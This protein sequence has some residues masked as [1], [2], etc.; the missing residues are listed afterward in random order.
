MSEQILKALM[1][2]FAIIANVDLNGN[3]GLSRSV[4][5]SYLEK[6]LNKKLQEEYIQVFDE[7][8]ALHHSGFEGYEESKKRTS[9]NSVQLLK[10]C[11]Q[12]NK[13]LQQEQKIFVLI[14]LLEF[15]KKGAEI[16]ETEQDFAST[17]A[18]AFNISEN[19]YSTLH[20]FV[21][22]ESPAHKIKNKCIEV[23]NILPSNQPDGIKHIFKDGLN[24]K[25]SFLHI[26]S[27]NMF[28]FKYRGKSN[29]YL[30]GNIVNADEPYIFDKGSAIRGGKL[31]PIY[32]S[33]IVAQFL[34]RSEKDKINF[35][36][37]N[38]V[39]KFKNSDAGIQKFN[40][41]ESSGEL[42]GIMGGSG[43]GKSTLLNIL[44]GNLKPQE[45][46]VSVNGIN[47]HEEKELLEGVIGFV[48]QDDLLIEELT[49]Y[50]NLYYN[51]RLCFANL[52]EEELLESVTKTLNDL[53]LSE[54]K[55]LQVGNPLNKVISG[56]QRKR[57]NIALELIREPSILFVDEPTSG[58]SS[59]DSEMVMDL[60]KE[61]THK[62]KLVIINIHQPS[63][64][65]YKMFD[66]LVMLDK[67]GYL[68]YYGNPLE[69][70][71]YFKKQSGFANAD[72]SEC[73]YCGNVNPEQ[74]L[75]IIEGKIV[76]ENGK[77][78]KTRKK[79]P[80]EW[81]KLYNTELEKKV[82]FN[83]GTLKLPNTNFLLPSK[84]EQFKIF[85]TR[86]VLS[87]ITNKQYLLINFLEAPLLAFILGYFSKYIAGIPGGDPNSYVFSLNENLPSYLFMSIVCS[88]FLGLSVSAEEI[89]R[90]R[91]ILQRE[92]FL[93]LSKWS[94]LNS[95]VFF[96]F[97]VSAI[98]V[99][100]FLL[101]GNLILEIKGLG[102]SYFMILFS[103]ACFANMLGLNISASLN[104][105]VT[106]YILI[107]FILVPQLLL[108]GVIVKFDK[109][110]KSIAS[111]QFVSIAG[112]LMISRWAY[113]AL[114]VNQ[115]RN[116]EYQKHFFDFD[117]TQSISGFHKNILIPELL[118]N[119]D[120]IKSQR[121]N[122]EKK[123][124]I[125][126]KYQLLRNEIQILSKHL[127]HP[128]H[129]FE[130]LSI[131]GFNSE[132]YLYTKEYLYQI[133][134]YFSSMYNTAY[135][136]R[137]SVAKNLIDKLGDEGVLDL[138]RRHHNEA[139]SNI[140]QNYEELRQFEIVDN[141]IVQKTQP[142][143]KLPE[144]NFGR[145]HFYASE[146]I[147]L[148]RKYRT[149]WFNVSII[150]MTTFL[151]YITLITD[152]FARMIS[153]LSNIKLKK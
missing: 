41:S 62:G 38:V 151:L 125:N 79:S 107:P 13:N 49:V 23:S 3:V 140:V 134:N 27:T 44:N 93:N 36:A 148:G 5:I 112:D 40:F 42:I 86:N 95:K 144:S 130:E 33:D 124:I 71:T 83:T 61:Q 146:K 104:S 118:T 69:A 81:N 91:R 7:F 54:I 64:N 1:Q 127:N 19:E 96:L 37:T 10:I 12:I 136:A 132:T 82:I 149:E 76:D 46:I 39:F 21:F 57:L 129:K 131:G 147:I 98:Q 153:K 103:T 97:T 66:K 48:P 108:S 68:I 74:V 87:K 117:K 35:S 133:K 102:F 88:L 84:F 121:N 6:H 67:G 120:F 141:R 18:E 70:I 51:A 137:D 31:K 22:S 100:T 122:P 80:E 143:Y 89:I 73:N 142:I 135:Y 45:G 113:E 47:L 111:H 11:R 14:Q 30:N 16:T 28:S 20:T 114:A 24:G 109:L 72:E 85:L 106:I 110:H 52:T 116:N 150:W 9:A 90:D 60:L 65:I 25:I 56:G 32:Y 26:T 77:L 119:L 15:I 94:Y 145:A 115:F 17:V 29:L 63:S 2:L 58:L 50:E 8:V 152:S 126:E 4:V 34:H 101:L 99:I 92:H 55:D 53:D 138:K 43:V 75:Q 128:F 139:L 78:T 105:V 123:E 59:M